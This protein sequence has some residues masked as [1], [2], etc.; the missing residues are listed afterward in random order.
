MKTFVAKED[1]TVKV[2]A[3]LKIEDALR[4]R[5]TNCSIVV[6][7]FL[8]NH[9]EY[10]GLNFRT[11]YVVDGDYWVVQFFSKEPMLVFNEEVAQ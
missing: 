10:K 7:K 5:H 2:V 4:R 1:A 9:P 8:D 11:D 3:E 6:N